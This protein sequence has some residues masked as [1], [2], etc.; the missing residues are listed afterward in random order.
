VPP[1]ILKRDQ[2]EEIFGQSWDLLLSI[3]RDLYYDLSNCLSG[4]K[5]DFDRVGEVFI[6]KGDFLKMYKKVLGNHNAAMRKYWMCT[7]KETKFAA[8]LEV[9]FSIF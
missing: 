5:V 6:K 4:T 2:F 8:F 7:K 1:P 3:H 9:R